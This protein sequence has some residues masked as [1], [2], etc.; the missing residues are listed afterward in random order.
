MFE[1]LKESSF[2]ILQGRDYSIV[3]RFQFLALLQLFSYC[4]DCSDPILIRFLHLT[5]QIALVYVFMGLGPTWVLH[6]HNMAFAHG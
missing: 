5:I 6:M 4:I 3:F 1:I 2:A